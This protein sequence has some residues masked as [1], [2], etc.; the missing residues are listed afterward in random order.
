MSMAYI[1]KFYGVPAKRGAWIVFNN[2]RCR[3]LSAIGAHLR[4]IS[5]HGHKF[6]IHPTCEVRYEEE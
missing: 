6:I 1:R 3:I 4:V 5:E 2:V